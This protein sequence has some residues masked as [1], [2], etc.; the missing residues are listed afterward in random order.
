[1][2]RNVK[3]EV[4]VR[5]VSET[6]RIEVL[7][8]LRGLAIFGILLVNVTFYGTSLQTIMWRTA[9]WTGWDK[10]VQIV[11][12]LLVEGKFLAVFSFLFG[13]GMVI[14]QERAE[15]KG[16]PF[17]RLFARRL[18]LLLLFGL[19]HGLLLWYGDILF[20]YALLGFVLLLFRRA[21]P[22][23]LVIW[24]IGLLGLLLV[25]TW[26]AGGVDGAAVD[27]E[28]IS[29]AVARDKLI[30]GEGSYRD[31]LPLRAADWLMSA[32]NQIVFYPQILAMFLIG[33]YFARRRLLHDLREGRR[34]LGKIALGAGLLGWSS[35]ALQGAVALGVKRVEFFADRIEVFAA[36]IGA[37]SLALFY[38][39]VIG[40]LFARR[41]D[42]R[43]WW[44]VVAVGRTAFTNYIM[45][46]VLCTFIF[47]GY[48]LG[49]Y[50]QTGPAL[51]ALIA[52]GV[53]AV[54]LVVSFV[55]MSRFQAGPLEWLWRTG[56][57]KMRTPL[58]RPP[59]A[60]PPQYGR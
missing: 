13:Y 47:Y 41:G 44:P 14:F 45:Q 42:G 21:K 7:D 38:I 16:R 34:R 53:Y 4:R 58:R 8:V 12:Q 51:D 46:S 24:A 48:G 3:G 52:T 39:T 60:T 40:L 31:V 25:V 27:G 9:S 30:Y 37:P 35:A 56:T 19:A 54:Q 15:A 10:A 23:T 32:A 20:H 5:A 59:S 17:T 26:D 11:L 43:L 57:Y 49:L 55:W 6:E 50:G 22:A 29:Q 33:A 18:T 28:F 36:V 2:M 1:M